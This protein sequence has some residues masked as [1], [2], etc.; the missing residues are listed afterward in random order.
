MS[1]ESENFAPPEPVANPVDVEKQEEEKLKAK[2]SI[3][4]IGPGARPGGHSAFLQK[5]LQKGVSLSHLYLNETEWCTRKIK[6]HSLTLNRCAFCF[7]FFSF[8]TLAKV[9]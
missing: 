2:Y 1:S 4:G 6:I 3:G 7:F 5:R 9:L 8:R